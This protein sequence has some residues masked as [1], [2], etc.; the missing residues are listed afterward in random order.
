MHSLLLISGVVTTATFTFMMQCSQVAPSAVRATHY[1]LLAT[2]EI[3]GKLTFASF[4]GLLTDLLG[5]TNV[6]IL[7]IGL[8]FLV[9]LYLVTCPVGLKNIHKKGS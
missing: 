4:M 2:V 9:P 7:F 6:Y 8:S 5:Y 1:S 3:F